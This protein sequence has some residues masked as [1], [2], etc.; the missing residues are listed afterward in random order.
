MLL[1]IFLAALGPTQSQLHGRPCPR[2]IHGIFGALI[3]R[4]DDVR[5][6]ADL[7]FH[8]AFRTEEVL[9]T[10]QMGTERYSL[11]IHLTQRVEAEYL[12]AA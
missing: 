6:Q 10:V 11:F 4:H 5:A 8:R 1:E 3:K 12:E 9:R 2:R 7:Y